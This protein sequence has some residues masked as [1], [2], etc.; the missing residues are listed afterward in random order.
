VGKHFG[1]PQCGI[2]RPFS[3][4]VINNRV[5]GNE[6]SRDHVRTGSNPPRKVIQNYPAAAERIRGGMRFEWR[7]IGDLKLIDLSHQL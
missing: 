1:T 5:L 6:G 4:R 7:L 3:L 2:S